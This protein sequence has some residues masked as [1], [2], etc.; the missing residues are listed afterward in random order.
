MNTEENQL[1]SVAVVCLCTVAEKQIKSECSVS[2]DQYLIL[3]C[4]YDICPF[5]CT[6]QWQSMVVTF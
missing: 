4:H 3:L 5:P 1:L 2:C 6:A